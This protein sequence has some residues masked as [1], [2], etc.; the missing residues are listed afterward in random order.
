MPGAL[1]PLGKGWE[2]RLVRVAGTFDVELSAQAVG[3]F[4]TWLDLMVS[5]NARV[6]LTAARG[7]DELIDLM[8]ADACLLARELPAGARVV[9]IGSGAGAPGMALGFLRPDLDVTL[10]EPLQKRVSFLRTVLGSAER[11]GM[12][13]VRARGEE[14]AARQPG[15]DVAIARATLPPPAWLELGTKLVASPAGSVWVL[16][17]RDTPP[18]CNGWHAVL[19]REY[20]WPLTGAV[21]RALRYERGDTSSRS[22]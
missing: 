16:L 12:R 11:R 1:E 10:V 15:F 9:D 8:V 13:V 3:L 5:W 14:I 17:A 18:V 2:E 20:L 4:A 21:R 6:D 22:A 19:D 7:A